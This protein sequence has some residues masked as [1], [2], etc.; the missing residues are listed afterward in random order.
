M[1]VLDEAER[2]ECVLLHPAAALPEKMSRDA[3]GYDLRTVE[4]SV[5]KSGESALIPTGIA[6]RYPPGCYGR[7][8]ARSG[9]AV[10]YNLMVN[11]GVCDGDY[12]GEIKVLLCNAGP[13]D[14]VLK[15]GDRVA[16]LIV[17]RYASPRVF[18]VDMLSATERGAEGFGSTGVAEMTR[19][20]IADFFSSQF[21]ANCDAPMA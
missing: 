2:M 1:S 6:L 13:T 14:F 12:T 19:T 18:Q 11:A 3:A 10:K 4:D 7:I 21:K 17:E 5:V 20:T 8:A 16:Q 9:L 15:S